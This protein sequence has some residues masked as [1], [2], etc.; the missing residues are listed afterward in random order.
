MTI[1]RRDRLS[2]NKKGR[3]IVIAL[4]STS[5]KLPQLPVI[6]GDYL[7]IRKSYTCAVVEPSVAL[8]LT[9]TTG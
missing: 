4:V 7:I 6:F 3:I 1:N 9:M 5:D 2:A 8:N